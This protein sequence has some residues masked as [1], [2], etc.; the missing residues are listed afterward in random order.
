[1]E[2]ELTEAHAARRGGS[3]AAKRPTGSASAGAL[4]LTR[5]PSPPARGARLSARGTLVVSL[6]RVAGVGSAD[7]GLG[8]TLSL[9]GMARPRAPSPRPAP[10]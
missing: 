4:A 10:T 1:V 7:G 8:A 9:C 6:G 3:P 2:R 5:Q